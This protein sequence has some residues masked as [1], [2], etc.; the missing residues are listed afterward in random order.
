METTN[1][2]RLS[3]ARELRRRQ[4][5]AES[6]LWSHL[7]RNWCGLKWRRQHV[8]GP[9][10]VDFCFLSAHLVVELDGT[11]HREADVHEQDRWRTDYLEDRGFH[12]LRFTNDAVLTGADDVLAAIHSFLDPAGPTAP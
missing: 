4:T 11:I 10:V 8:V 1:S 6:V 5:P 2:R 12:V 9:F 7:R 3:S